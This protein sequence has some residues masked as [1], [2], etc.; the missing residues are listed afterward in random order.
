MRL[1]D[2]GE[3]VW[4]V[5]FDEKGGLTAPARNVLLEEVAARG[6]TDLFVFS[7]GWGTSE[8]GARAMYDAMFPLMREAAQGTDALATIGFAGIYWPS[9]WFPDTPATVAV[10]GGIQADD[11]GALQDDSGSGALSGAEIADSLASGY[12]DPQQQQVILEIGRL[13][14]EGA[15]A[16]A[17]PDPSDHESPADQEARIARIH[18]LVRSLAPAYPDGA[19]DEAGEDA[20]ESALLLSENPKDDYQR[21][22]DTFGT[23][24]AEGAPQ[25]L[26]DWF[27]KAL[28]GAK[29]AVRVLSYSTMKVRAG[30]I[31]RVGLGPLLSQLHVGAPDLRVHLLGH[32]FGARLVS[33][34]LAGVGEADASPV[35]SL[36]LLQG[37]FSHWS[38]SHPQ[39]NP[40]A[41]PGPLHQYADRVHGP[42]VATYSVFDWAVCQWYPKA[43]FL[44]RQDLEAEDVGRWDGM[45][46]DGYQAVNPAA[47]IAMPQDGGTNYSF[48]AGTFYRVDCAEVINDVKQSAFAGAHSDIRKRPVAELCVAAAAAH[49]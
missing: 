46:A 47:D 40:F 44:A 39:D 49:A 43:S 12:T 6:V 34:A 20:G 16:A 21:V 25:G 38:F 9:L 23:T 35:A 26:G 15:A 41:R 14:D 32:S 24:A 10:A 30:D 36:L 13:I 11:G 29:D 19:G 37:A 7:H 27:R 3:P 8:Q 4:D 1:L 18:A 2:T 5:R 42:L 31:G 22:A 48:T 45:G 17:A 28:N 33:F